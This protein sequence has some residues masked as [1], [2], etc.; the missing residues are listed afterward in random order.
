[1]RNSFIFTCALLCAFCISCD[2]KDNLQESGAANQDLDIKV[3][4]IS[5]EDPK[6]APLKTTV[7]HTDP[8]YQSYIEFFE[9]VYDTMAENYYQPV[10]REN[11]DRFIDVFNERIYAQLTETGKSVDFVKWR[12][13]SF[14]ID[15]LKEEEDI[16]SA[17]YPPK[18]AKEY[19]QTA[20]GKRIDLGITGELLKDGYR[21]TDV[22]IRSDAFEKGLRRGDV[23]IQIDQMN[24]LDSTMTEIGEKLRPLEDEVVQISFLDRDKQMRKIEVVSREYFRQMLHLIETQLPGIYGLRLEKFNR[25]TSEDMFRYLQLFKTQ[26][27]NGEMEGFILDLRDNPGGP[28]LAAREISSFFLTPGETLTYFKKHDRDKVELDIPA[29]PEEFHVRVPMVILIDENTGSAAEMF[30]GIMQ[31][32]GRAVLMGETSAGQVMLKSM[33]HFDDESMVLL[34]TQRGHYPD[35]E[36]YSF[37][38]LTPDRFNGQ[39]NG[40]DIID[41]ASKYLIYINRQE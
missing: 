23:L 35:G 32:K 12:S 41:F 13:T 30:S 7:Q 29:I 5:L 40:D 9:E 31:R 6:N 16:F 14:L 36:P 25:K 11:F 1:M 2:K 28:P 37:S 4:R 22:E 24:V 17:F 10:A 19:E 20:L 8:V 34:I 15:Y 33:F 3:T 27:P 26:K 21:V 18:P 38:G 39:M